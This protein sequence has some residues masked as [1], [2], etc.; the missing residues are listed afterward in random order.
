MT[1]RNDFADSED[2]IRR[3]RRAASDPGAPSGSPTEQSP[4]VETGTADGGRSPRIVHR[5]A[6]L[7]P[8]GSIAARLGDPPFSLE[9]DG[10]ES[11]RITTEHVDDT[12][13]E[14]PSRG[15][16]L[17]RTEVDFY[18]GGS[19][20]IISAVV[21]EPEQV[22]GQVRGKRWI[23]EQTLGLRVANRRL[24]VL[25]YPDEVGG[26]GHRPVKVAETS[27]RFADKG[28][29]RNNAVSVA[30]GGLRYKLSPA[31]EKRRGRVGDDTAIRRASL[32]PHGL[33]HSPWV[34]NA[35]SPVPLA[36]VLVHWHLLM[37]D[38]IHLGGGGGG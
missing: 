3:A 36:A 32:V 35:E 26:H 10:T 13:R 18:D 12:L 22:A 29:G 14:S 1:G 17:R 31:A 24:V 16:M 5:R 37:G 34:V 7:V 19:R 27:G 11:A 33:W 25:E 21:P 8:A 4:D 38:V 2:L 20:W 9:A 28:K 6:K 23:A 30:I 15:V